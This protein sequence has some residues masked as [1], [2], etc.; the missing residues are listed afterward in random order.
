MRVQEVCAS[1]AARAHVL[2]ALT[3]HGRANKLN[4]LELVKALV[5]EPAVFSVENDLLTP[6]FKLKRAPLLKHYRKEVDVM[7]AEVA[8]AGATK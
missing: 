7:Y 4:S 2:E 5:L 8:K 3:A 6:T 1:P